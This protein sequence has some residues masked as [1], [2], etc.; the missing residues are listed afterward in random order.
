MLPAVVASKE[1]IADCSVMWEISGMIKRY[2]CPEQ[3][4]GGGRRGEKGSKRDLH[5]NCSHL[6]SHWLELVA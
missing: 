3:F 4:M 6:L 1:N 2:H 5:A